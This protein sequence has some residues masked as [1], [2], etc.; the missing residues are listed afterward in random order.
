V[1]VLDLG[2][3]IV[4]YNTAALLRD[5]LQSIKDSQGPYQVAVCVVDN[6]SADESVAMVRAE[7]PAVQ[8]IASPSN[9]GFSKANNKG[10]RYFGFGEAHASAPPNRP[11]YALLLN[12]DT[13]LTP[14]ALQTM[15]AFMDAT[16]HA[17]AAGPKLLLLDGSLD[18]ACRR[19]FP[20]PQVSF[21]RLTGLSKLFPRH[22]RFG[23][24]NLTYLNPNLPTDVDAVV[25]AFML[26]RAEAL[27]Q[28]GLMD[29]RYFMY[30][31]DLDWAF[32]IK[33]A[34]WKIYYQPAATVWH[35]KRAASRRSA[36][37]QVEF[38]RAMDLFYQKHYAADSP[39]W[40]HLMI[41]LGIRLKL[42]QAKLRVQSSRLFQ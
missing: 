17:G 1:A 6:A 23:Q 24:Y 36:K 7:F 21:Y 33:Q 2:I 34:G 31:E 41:V 19:S 14:T 13:R 22:P 4:N 9:D 3:V 5:C 28:A 32:A 35:V 25:G 40:L 37:A 29:E 39:F 16:P 20:T 38:Y 10:L 15:L 18:V 11:R 42:L 26:V 30:G 12:P 27:Q 8:C